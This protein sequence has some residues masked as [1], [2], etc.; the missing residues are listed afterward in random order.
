[1][2][3]THCHLT[4]PDFAEPSWPGG[5]GAVLAEAQRAGVTGCI[6]ISTTTR[7]ARRALAV[8]HA[9]ARVWCSAGVHPLYAD[10]GPHEWEAMR[11]V[12]TD[13]KCVA[14]GELG[15]DNHYDQPA[16][17]SQHAVLETQ[18][19]HLQAWKAD[20]LEKPV[21]LHCREAF[22]DLI[23]I[24]NRTTLDPAKFVFHCFTG[25]EA[26]MRRVLDFGAHVSFTGVVTYRNAQAVRRAAQLVPADRIMVETD[27]PF[28]SPDPHRGERPCR[29][30][31]CSVTAR[32]LAE[33]RG[34]AFES[35]HE[36]VN[37]TTRRFFG[38]S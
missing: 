11:E 1:M 32:R 4:F 33:I 3:D 13:P 8:A 36:Q 12:G 29:P 37:E 38:V 20:G 25:E 15:L 24:L 6:T 28:L 34:V 26:D 5:V 21:I 23:P 19:T 10:D 22:A 2:I 9:H 7:D 35:F 18:L 30:W 27:A 14:W 16:R 31:M 17:Q